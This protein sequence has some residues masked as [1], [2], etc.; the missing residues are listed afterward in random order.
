[1]K[2]TKL[3][4]I[5]GI[6]SLA[7]FSTSGFGAFKVGVL[8]SLSGTMAIS[9]TSLKDLVMM[10]VNAPSFSPLRFPYGSCK[11]LPEPHTLFLAGPVLSGA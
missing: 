4:K 7:L 1:M 5:I 6:L 8:R 2:L 10:A 3:K 11:R 9:E